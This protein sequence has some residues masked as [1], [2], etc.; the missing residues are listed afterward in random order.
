MPRANRNIAAASLPPKS[1]NDRVPT[2]GRLSSAVGPPPA[3]I[4]NR[5]VFC[6]EDS[7]LD[8]LSLRRADFRGRRHF[9]Q[10]AGTDVVNVTINR[11]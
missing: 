4:V 7:K 2:V 3:T 1:C 9:D 5:E 11:Y 6:G 8:S 10:F